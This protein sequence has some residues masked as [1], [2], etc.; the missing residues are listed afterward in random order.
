M[1][2]SHIGPEVGVQ[3]S[4]EAHF[5]ENDGPNQRVSAGHGIDDQAEQLGEA[6]GKQRAKL[7]ET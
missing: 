6:V 2:H 1:R 3:E 5:Q 7:K 4:D